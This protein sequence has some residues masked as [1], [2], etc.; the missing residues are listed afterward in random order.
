[1]R[2]TRIRRR[3]K[4]RATPRKT[5]KN[6]HKSKKHINSRR[7]SR[8]R[9]MRGGVE[10]IDITNSISFYPNTILL[11]YGN[12]Y[13]DKKYYKTFILYN[14]SENKFYF[15]NYE[16]SS[17]ETINS[18]SKVT[19]YIPIMKTHVL[20]REYS[21]PD[22]P[23]YNTKHFDE[24]IIL[25]KENNIDYE[26]KNKI[27]DSI[28]PQPINIQIED[29]YF[30]IFRI[31][32]RETY[33]KKVLLAEFKKYVTDPINN[34]AFSFIFQDANK[35]IFQNSAIP[36]EYWKLDRYTSD[37]TKLEYNPIL[38]IKEQETIQKLKEIYLSKEEE[39]QAHL[40][41]KEEEKQAH[42]L[43]ERI[44]LSLGRLQ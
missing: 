35:D 11:G 21:S 43:S 23:L 7:Y 26:V 37:Y 31:A 38:P 6:I 36:I 40:L 13:K 9:V 29:I 24:I 33:N 30:H 16:N 27:I 2:K 17:I 39:K 22:T 1:M 8:R 4:K 15:Y 20:E 14:K 34:S 12:Y 41:S 28:E 25:F 44:K 19:I 10:N 32:H 42:L 5:R 3:F 18:S